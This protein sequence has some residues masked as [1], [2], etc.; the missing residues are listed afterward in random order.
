[1]VKPTEGEEEG[2]FTPVTR[3]GKGKKG[4][5]K[6]KP[7]QINLTPASYASAAASATNT[8]QPEA[9]PKPNDRLPAITEVTV[10]RS[11]AGGH[12]DSQIEM[13]IR[14]RAP[15][16]IVREVRLKNEKRSTQPN[17]APSG[18]VERPST[19]QG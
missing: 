1:M 4:K 18:S 16:A 13:S 3:N 10:I 6:T 5:G 14:A 12:A 7:P 19:Q 9:P 15:D 8:K 17:P 2:D 11:G